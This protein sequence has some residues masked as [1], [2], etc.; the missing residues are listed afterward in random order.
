M[1]GFLFHFACSEYVLK[2]RL[3]LQT[4]AN[5]TAF[6]LGNVIPDLTKDKDTSH[7]RNI[8]ISGWKTPNLTLAKKQ[9]LAS[10]TPLLLGC[11]CHLYLDHYFI[12]YHLAKRYMLVFSNRVLD[13]RH[14][15]IYDVNHFLSRKGLYGAYDCGNSLLIS[16]GLLPDGYL[17]LPA[18]PPLTGLNNF[19]NRSEKNWHDQVE[20]YLSSVPSRRSEVFMPE[21]LRDITLTAGQLFLNEIASLQ[22]N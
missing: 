7:Y 20:N 15:R 17:N 5:R 18:V 21:E 13:F 11:Y 1:P 16:E 12:S 8:R 10:P 2:N 3:D 19:D 6:L 14:D 22:F 9:L 4:E